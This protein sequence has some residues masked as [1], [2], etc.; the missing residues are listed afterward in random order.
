MKRAIYL[1]I[2]IVLL[3]NKSSAQ[4][5]QT[6]PL[7]PNKYTTMED[8]YIS[9]STSWD[10][11]Y[12]SAELGKIG[13]SIDGGNGWQR[14]YIWRS[15]YYFDMNTIPSNAIITNATATSIVSGYVETQNPNGTIIYSAPIAINPNSDQYYCRNFTAMDTLETR[16]KYHS[17]GDPNYK[18][19][20]Y[21]EDTI[22][23]DVT[24]SV[25]TH[26]S[27]RY[28][29]FAGSSNWESTNNSYAFLDIQISITYYVPFSVTL[30]NN[31]SGGKM[32]IVAPGINDTA[33]SV[34]YTKT[35]TKIGDVFTLTAKPQIDNAGYNRVW[36]NYAPNNISWWRKTVGELENFPAST[37][38][39]NFNA[40][41]NDQNATYEAGL[42]KNIKVNRKEQ[43]ETGNAM[44]ADSIFIVE[45]N[46]DSIATPAAKTVGSDIYNFVGW[47]DGDMNATKTIINPTSNLS[48]TAKYKGNLRTGAPTFSDAKNQRRLIKTS[49]G[50][51]IMVYESMG[52]IWLTTTTNPD[53][54]GWEGEVRLNTNIGQSSNPTFSNA[55][56]DKYLIAWIEWNGTT[57]D[58]H[59]QSMY[60]AGAH[61]FGWTGLLDPNRIVSHRVLN[62]I[63]W[64]NSSSPCNIYPRANARPVVQ[65]SQDATSIKILYAME[66]TG[67]GISAG[68]IIVPLG[69]D[70]NN[71]TLESPIG[72][73]GDYKLSTNTSDKCPVIINLPS[74]YGYPAITRIYYLAN[75]SGHRVAE[76]DYNS[77]QTT[78]LSPTDDNDYYSL[79]GAISPSN[80]CF[81]L[82]ASALRGSVNV[83]NVYFKPTYYGTSQPSL[84]T[85]YNAFL[86]PSIMMENS[87]GFGSSPMNID[88]KATS[89]GTWYKVDN[90]GS[91][92]NIG[93]AA[94]IAGMFL[95]EN[96]TAGERYSM[97]VKHNISPAKL[98]LS[99]STGQALSKLS[100]GS[101]VTNSRIIFMSENKKNPIG[102]LNISDADMTILDTIQKGNQVSVKIKTAG[103]IIS[104]DDTIPLPIGIDVLRN[105]KTIRSIAP[106][107]WNKISSND[108]QDL[109]IGDVLRLTLNEN[110]NDIW[111]YREITIKEELLPKDGLEDG[112]TLIPLK[113]DITVYP[114]PFNPST[115]FRIDVH[116]SAKVQLS[117]YN[118]LGQKIATVVDGILPAGSNEFKFDG[119]SLTS[120]MYIYRLKIDNEVR[121]GRMMLLK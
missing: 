112:K 117:V 68:R 1:W 48:Y 33:A 101:V 50:Y 98:E 36:N 21:T 82:T 51:Y 31:F 83:V 5:L 45:L 67:L 29:I 108:L 40:A 94:N 44:S 106:S 63:P 85:V 2:F 81:A 9:T 89:G 111:W 119:T 52:D 41:I 8:R 19:Q 58:L 73:A 46:S 114:N 24:D 99:N 115:T 18:N 42:R 32:G 120:G 55:V 13:H 70:L 7:S 87:S 4:G 11:F 27:N 118:M 116:Q 97:M 10:R 100:E 56:G 84:S 28:I 80:H 25:R 79:Q 64:Q 37:I 57:Y 3:V 15:L 59:L 6:V 75:S 72:A 86:Q 78:L 34:P 96:V 14:D 39:Y 90:S 92:T 38:V 107:R 66:R 76:Y 102:T 49:N 16:F 43:I 20:R 22:N 65:L 105:G 54:T 69:Q 109:Q 91:M 61:N 26:L 60:I 17:S 104:Q 71:A 53:G 62:N 12:Q 35:G 103:P 88:M 74:V 47:T 113:S 93:L 23:F 77:K 121:S 95:R 110:K 30:R